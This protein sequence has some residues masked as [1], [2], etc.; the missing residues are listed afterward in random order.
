MYLLPSNPSIDSRAIG[1]RLSRMALVAA[2][3][4]SAVVCGVARA[5]VVERRAP[6]VSNVVSLSSSGFLEVAQ[7]WLTLR[8]NTT[9]EGKDAASVQAQLKA[10]MDGAM[11]IARAGA[12]AD[13]QLQVR[14]GAFGV[15]PRYDKNGKIS[16]W[17]GSTE[18]VME[19]RDFTRIART[20]GQIQALTVSSM[21]FSL[22][23]EAQQKLE[24]DVQALAIDRFKRRASEVA[25]GFGF[26]DYKLGEI[27]ISSA[28]QMDGR[29]LQ[30][31]AMAMEAKSAFDQAEPLAMEPGFSKVNVTVSGT[32]QLK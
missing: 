20:A 13:Q 18:L 14:S 11:V 21:A 7:D 16:G 19:G 32:V 22:S 9:R 29:M 30:R 15:Y 1:A 27:N 25:K 12:A 28:D 2:L 3:A 10:A 31:G 24:S 17:Q 8:M 23:R 5:D 26:A 4:A 6:V